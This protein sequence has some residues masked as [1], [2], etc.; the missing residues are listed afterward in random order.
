MIGRTPQQFIDDLSYGTE[1]VF[2]YRDRTLCVQGYVEE[3]GLWTGTMVQWEPRIEKWALW[4]HRAST[5]A[6]C[7]DDFLSAPLFDGRTFWE[8]E[9]EFEVIFA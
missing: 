8:A 4:Q 6:E 5:M 7:L 3:D 1:Q 9:K 2:I